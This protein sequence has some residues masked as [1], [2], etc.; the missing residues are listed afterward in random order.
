MSIYAN[1]S[2][3]QLQAE[4]ESQKA[5]LASCKEQNLKLNMARGK[6]AKQQ[7][8]AVSDI[9][10]VITTGDEC[11]DGALDTRNYGD[12]A[13]IP[14]AREYWAD[15][16]GCQ[17]DQTFIGGGFKKIYLHEWQ[18]LT[19]VGIHYHSAHGCALILCKDAHSQCEEQIK[20][21]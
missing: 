10:S 4:L 15:V 19:A 20:Y 7:L 14:S 2:K 6:P 5:F 12:L 18:C 3:Q 16:L 11:F 8:D 1:M 21:V 17:A 9:L 13:G